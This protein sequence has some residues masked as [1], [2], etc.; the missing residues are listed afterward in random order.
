MR[1][2]IYNN[3]QRLFRIINTSN[4]KTNNTVLDRGVLT[5]KMR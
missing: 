1:I 5:S 4:P 3:N 2:N